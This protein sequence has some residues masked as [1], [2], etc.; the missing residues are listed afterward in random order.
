M[1]LNRSPGRD[2]ILSFWYKKLYIYRHKLT[3]LYQSTYNGKEHL[4][5]WLPRARTKL[6]AKNEIIVTKNYRTTACLNLMQKIYTSFLNTFLSD[7]YFKN[8][9]ISLGQAAGRK[10]IWGCT[11]QLMIKKAIMTEIRKN[12]PNLFNLLPLFLMNG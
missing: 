11:E 1:Q 10:C 4:L 2:L 7:H 5:P 8:Q 3:K 9:I 6:L 12:P